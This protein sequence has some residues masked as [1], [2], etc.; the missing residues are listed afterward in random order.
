[1]WISE[2]VQ[3]TDHIFTLFTLIDHY[4]NKEKEKLF[5]CFVDFKKA[6]D[7]VDHSFL[8]KKILAYGI[9][10]KFITLIRSMYRQVKSCIRSKYGITNFFKFTKGV[11]QGCLLSPLL[12]ALFLNDLEDYLKVNGASGIDLWDIKI[13]LLL[14]ADDLILISNSEEDLKAQ[15]RILGSYALEYKMEVNSKKTKVMVYND[16]TWKNAEKLFGLIGQHKICTTDWYK[17]LGVIFDNKMSFKKQVE[18]LTEKAEKCLCLVKNREWKG[19]Q[20]RTFLYL[21]DHLISPILSSGSVVWGNQEW[22]ELERLH[23]FLCKFALGV[24]SSTPNDG[25]YAELG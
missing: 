15:M 17:Y 6:F 10:G 14:Y 19:F 12:F 2:G 24:K 21:F 11:C 9:S 3:R 13:C 1:M 4:V 22:I 7:E 25:I 18:M 16:K 23:L 5:F 8:W 20:P